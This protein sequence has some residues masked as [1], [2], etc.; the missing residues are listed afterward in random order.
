MTSK[1][2][3]IEFPASFA[4]VTKVGV[5]NQVHLSILADS[6][7]I[8]LAGAIFSLTSDKTEIKYA[9]KF[10]SQKLGKSLKVLR[11]VTCEASLPPVARLSLFGCKGRNGVLKCVCNILLISAS[12]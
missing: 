6:H 2:L 4:T 10:R 8:R 3:G 12:R 11:S 1:L 5:D 7:G 9:C